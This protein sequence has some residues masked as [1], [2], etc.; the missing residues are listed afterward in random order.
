MFCSLEEA[1]EDFR[2]GKFLVL[3]DAE[4]REDEG[5]LI[6][7]A[8]FITAAKVNLML[9]EARG[10]FLFPAPEEHWCKLDIPLIQPRHGDAK[11]PRFGLPFDAR[12]GISTG[13]S[14]QDRATTVRAAL[15]PGAGPD[16]FAIPG[17]VLPLAARQGGLTERQG[18]TEGA[19]ELARQA[20]LLPAAVMSEVL[21]PDGQMARGSQL[22]AFA[23][24]LGCKIIAIEALL[25][26][27]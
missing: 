20:G 3:V 23:A 26:D 17:H 24:R 1:L 22:Q 27:S 19:V 15:E 4:D 18:H 11:T 16:D 25:R 12:R 10:M 2:Q 9:A 14:A 8:Q 6:T 13:I 5:D 7:A 21:T